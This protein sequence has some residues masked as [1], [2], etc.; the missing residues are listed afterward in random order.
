MT[1]FRVTR[2]S[3]IAALVLACS[4]DGVTG[5][6]GRFDHAAATFTCGPADGP[7]LAIYLAPDP[8][9]SLEPAGVFVRVYVP[10]TIDQIRAVTWPISSN[11]DAAAWFH[12]NANNYEIATSGYLMVGSGSAGGT[13]EGSVDL[14]FP[15]AG[16]LHGAFHAEWIPTNVL[17]G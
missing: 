7:A 11:S 13:L 3:L 1:L 9:T 8:I 14:Q 5:L 16:H 4:S 15:I 6:A 12:R 10:G 2:F 17:C